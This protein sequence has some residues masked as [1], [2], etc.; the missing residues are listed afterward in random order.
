MAVKLR[1][2]RGT[3]LVELMVGL[4]A[5]MIV[6]ATLSMV[7]I[8]TMRG[9][10]RVSARVEATQRA[11]VVLSKITEQ[12]HSACTGPQIA[13]ILPTSTGTSLQFAHATGTQVSAVAPVPTKTVISFASGTLTQSNFALLS[14]TYPKWI[15]APTE[16]GTPTTLLTKVAPLSPGVVFEYLKFSNGAMVPAV[17]EVD[18]GSIIQVRIALN[19]TP[20][21][22]PVADPGAD[23]SIR[24]SAVLRLTPPSFAGT[25][26]PPCQ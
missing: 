17:P 14:G 24:D 25:S 7:L 22:T 12:L 18:A 21:R 3:T 10:A 4:A 13:P 6:L 15:W 2:E 16:T 26:A 1:D 11:R 19:A 23:S 8:A 5:G 9:S 20:L